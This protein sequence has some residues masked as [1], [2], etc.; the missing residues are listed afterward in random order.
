M[1][2]IMH[3]SNLAD[4]FISGKIEEYLECIDEILDNLESIEGRWP[5]FGCI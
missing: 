1:L 4:L 5:F 2:L 3:A